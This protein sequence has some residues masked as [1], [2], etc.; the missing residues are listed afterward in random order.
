M[1]RR[2]RLG[3]VIGYNWWREYN[4]EMFTLDTIAWEQRRE[5]EALGYDTEM[6]E[7][8]AANPRPNLKSLLVNNKGLND[9]NRYDPDDV[10][11]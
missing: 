3:R 5:E 1:A 11:H 9:P 6:D 4:M 10:V 2:D 7:F 8:E